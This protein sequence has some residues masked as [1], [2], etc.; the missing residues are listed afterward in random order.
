LSSD[1]LERL[2]GL[3]EKSAADVGKGFD[4]PTDDW[5]PMML[6]ESNDQLLVV[7][8]D[9]EFMADAGRKDLLAEE[10]LPQVVREAEAT[11][12]V[13]VISAWYSQYEKQTQHLEE[14]IAPSQDPDRKEAVV[15]LGFS[16]TNTQ[17]RMADIKRY[18]DR[19]PELDEWK[20]GVADP[21]PGRF[22]KPIQRALQRN[23]R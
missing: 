17:A 9:T 21:F 23:T 8:I 12:V 7:A 16:A 3:A 14:V 11:A 22:V 19:P 5:L 10:V 20:T 2:M 13:L 4:T 6:V 15:L 18:E 1:T